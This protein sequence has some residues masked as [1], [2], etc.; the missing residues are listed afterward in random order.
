MAPS[1]A[2]LL[3]ENTPL[4]AAAPLPIDEESIIQEE[5]NGNGVFSSTRTVNGNRNGDTLEEDKPLPKLQIFLLCFARM[6]EPIAFFGIF[7][8]IPQMIE[9]TGNV[10]E[11]DI[12]FYSGAIVCDFLHFS[13]SLCHI[14]SCG[15][16]I[17]PAKMLT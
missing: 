15:G 6:V 8:F 3:D 12:G 14:K 7:P 13:S 10:E 9:R 16:E 5:I 1:D 2:E 17:G 11:A 4:F